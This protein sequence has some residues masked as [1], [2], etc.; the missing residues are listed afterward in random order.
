MKIFWLGEKTF[1]C[2]KGQ[3]T[4]EVANYALIRPFIHHLTLKAI[5][6][7][8]QDSLKIWTPTSERALLIQ[9]ERGLQMSIQ[10]VYVNEIE[11]SL[12]F[13]CKSPCI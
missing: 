5:K 7:K 6:S 12:N 4:F 10:Q 3:L 8:L 9:Q 11:V 1:F 13:G 2:H